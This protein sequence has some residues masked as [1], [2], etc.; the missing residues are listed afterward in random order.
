[1][2]PLFDEPGTLQR[3]R[4]AAKLK[5]LAE[6]QIY[7]GTSSWK[8]EGW[9]GQI[10]SRERYVVRGRFAQKRFES[11]CLSEY[12]EV[13][14]VVCGDFSF[15]QFPSAEYWKRL[16]GSAGQ[17]LLFAFKVPED[18]TVAEFPLHARYGPRAGVENPSFLD[19]DLFRA[20]MTDLLEPYA[21]R[22]ASLIFE[23]G[24]FPKRTFE[25]VGQFVARLDEFLKRLPRGFQYAVEIRNPEFLFPEYFDC[26]R[27]HGVAH[28][29]NAWTRMPDL[30]EQI[31]IGDAWTADY[32]V[33]R[34]L[35]RKGRPYEDAVEKFAPYER[36]QEENP[37]ARGA[38]REMIRK[39]REQRRRAYIFVN[40][41]LEGNAPGT[42]EAI[43]ED[44]ED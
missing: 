36:V 41:R 13:F 44:D 15:Y 7:I 14:P 5:R 12:S 3:D 1:M 33:T 25:D 26:L 35:L 37:R 11:E 31:R 16:F 29:F 6:E 9:C 39:A 42:I 19:A 28:V 23:F 22:V 18:I 8:Y 21:G 17:D 32:F 38:I 34:A 43:L 10:Y 24:T 2:L 4:L 30:D 40:N 20:N 27:T